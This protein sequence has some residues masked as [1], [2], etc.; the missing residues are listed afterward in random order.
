MRRR[1]LMNYS[2]C[3]TRVWPRK[4][5]TKQ[6]RFLPR[7]RGCYL[8]PLLWVHPDRTGLTPG[9]KETG[10]FG[11]GWRAWCT[12]QG[13]LHEGIKLVASS[14][15]VL[16]FT[17]FR[18]PRRKYNATTI[19]HLHRF[20]FLFYTFVSLW[21]LCFVSED[22]CYSCQHNLM[23]ASKCYCSGLLVW[24]YRGGLYNAISLYY[25]SSDSN[26]DS[27]HWPTSPV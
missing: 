13:S 20:F 17:I 7:K 24:S 11:S 1:W 25:R 6:F 15:T 9:A 5:A 3:E 4:A 16:I 12:Q 10:D 18:S 8:P 2:G 22:L 14:F 27:N 26:S 23:G 21:I 19:C